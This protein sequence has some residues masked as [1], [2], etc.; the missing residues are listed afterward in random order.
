MITFQLKID[1]KTLLQVYRVY[2]MYMYDTDINT[3]NKSA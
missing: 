1:Q 3:D 2:G